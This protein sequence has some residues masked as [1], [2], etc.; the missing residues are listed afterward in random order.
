M[1][2]IY[3]STFFYYICYSETY[4]TQQRDLHGCIFDWVEVQGILNGDIVSRYREC[5]YVAP[6]EV[7]EVTNAEEVV[8]KFRSDE[9]ITSR[10]FWVKFQGAF[11]LIHLAYLVSCMLIF[12]LDHDNGVSNLLPTQFF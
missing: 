2:C 4:D 5:D 9:T 11:T 8:L 10:G 12:G 6:G 7:Y 3:S 1:F